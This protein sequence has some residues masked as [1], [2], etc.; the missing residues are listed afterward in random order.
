M[1]RKWSSL[2][3]SNRPKCIIFLM[4]KVLNPIDSMYS[5]IGD[6]FLSLKT[7]VQVLIEHEMPII[8]IWS[9][10]RI[11]SKSLMRS[12]A[13]TVY[14]KSFVSFINC[15]VVNIC[16]SE[17][18]CKNELKT[19]TRYLFPSFPF[20]KKKRKFDLYKRLF[21]LP[22]DSSFNLVV[23]RKSLM[24]IYY[25]LYLFLSLVCKAKMFLVLDLSSNQVAFRE[26]ANFVFFS[27]V[28]I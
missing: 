28:V 9:Y 18:K 8:P 5:S 20:S 17:S 4:P 23:F 15:I 22:M 3:D 26:V 11:W 7:K 1:N 12:W 24:R 25:I 21:C 19:K 10:E 14:Y 6:L 27:T 2:Y 13:V 16:L